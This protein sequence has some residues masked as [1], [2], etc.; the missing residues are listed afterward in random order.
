MRY[1]DSELRDFGLEGATTYATP[2]RL[3]V[4]TLISSLPPQPP[5]T[6]KVMLDAMK[7]PFQLSSRGKKVLGYCII[8]LIKHGAPPPR[9]VLRL[10]FKLSPDAID[11]YVETFI[12]LGFKFAEL[13]PED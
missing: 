12:R 2:S 5:E 8:Y 6:A 9:S 4:Q 1:S 13:I 10:S 7:S 11:F 3:D